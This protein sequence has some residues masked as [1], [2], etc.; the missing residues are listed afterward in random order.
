M[1]GIVKDKHPIVMGDFSGFWIR[2]VRGIQIINSSEL[3]IQRLMIAM[4]AYQ[5]C[6][7]QMVDPNAFAAIK[8]K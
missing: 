3:Y 6:D 1:E 8:S 2:N 4:M 5:R 7:A